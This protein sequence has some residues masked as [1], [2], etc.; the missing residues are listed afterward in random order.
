MLKR[1]ATVDQI[2][3]LKH[4]F[5]Q[6]FISESMSPLNRICSY[7]HS[8]SER[9]SSTPPR[10]DYPVQLHNYISLLKN[11]E[12]EYILHRLAAHSDVL[13]VWDKYAPFT[14][15]PFMNYVLTQ[16]DPQTG[17][18][19]VLHEDHGSNLLW[20]DWSEAE[21]DRSPDDTALLTIKELCQDLRVW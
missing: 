4:E 9:Y 14:D 6:D 3:L 17:Y 21:T 5:F 16:P 13:F 7:W 12:A 1:N 8:L 20:I 2:K 18:A 11:Y 10:F 19:Y 15:I